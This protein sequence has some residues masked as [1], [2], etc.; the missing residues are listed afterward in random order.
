VKLSERATA[1]IGH[2]ARQVCPYC[3]EQISPPNKR[4]SV[5]HLR[6]Y[7]KMIRAVFDNWPHRHERQFTSWPELR[8]WLQMKAGHRELVADLPIVGLH[9]ER[10][11]MLVEAA[12]RASG[13]YALPVVHGDMMAIYRPKSIAF[14]RLGH[15]EAVGLFADIEDVIRA[16]TGLDP[17]QLMESQSNFFD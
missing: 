4:R 15:L 17:T 6:R 14:A 16:E 9:K 3:D 2:N 8:A 13:S 7:F 1:G 10:A 11:T 12:I 5:P